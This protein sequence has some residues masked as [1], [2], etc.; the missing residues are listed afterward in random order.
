M[1]RGQVRYETLSVFSLSQK[2]FSI[3]TASSDDPQVGIDLSKDTDSKYTIRFV[4][5]PAL[6]GTGRGDIIIAG[7]TA[8]GDARFRL[9]VPYFYRLTR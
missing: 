9:T 6:N 5:D 4:L 1:N 8:D 3:E 2:G 7:A